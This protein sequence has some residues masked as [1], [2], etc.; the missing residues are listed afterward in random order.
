MGSRPCSARRSGSR[1]R[2]RIARFAEPA[3]TALGDQSISDAELSELY[4]RIAPLK[5]QDGELYA[6]KLADD[7]LRNAAFLWDPELEVNPA[8]GLEPIA[9]LVT[10]HS[11][12]A[13]SL[14]RPTYAEVV[15]QIPASLRELVSG[16]MLRPSEIESEQLSLGGNFHRGLVK[17]YAKRGEV[18]QPELEQA[19]EGLDAGFGIDPV[20]RYGADQ[21]EL[22]ERAA[23]EYFQI[24]MMQTRLD[25]GAD[26]DEIPDHGINDKS[27]ARYYAEVLVRCA[28]RHDQLS[29]SEAI[30][31]AYY[32]RL[33]GS[34]V[35]FDELNPYERERLIACT[36]RVIAAAWPER[37]SQD[38]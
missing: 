28:A 13:P 16:F 35:P 38:L 9:E 14:F 20:Q 23:R 12:S 1:P 8:S 10:W 18:T 2:P 25:P 37:A 19:I 15:T 33:G 7:E 4:T 32:A 34:R 27:I 6:V 30:A 36:E 22:I 29:D 3:D 26:W 24:A 31:R 17:L 11:F 5:E 21:P